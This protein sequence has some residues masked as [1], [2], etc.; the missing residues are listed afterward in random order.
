MITIHGKLIGVGNI[1]TY[2]ACGRGIELEVNGETVYLLGLT[3]EQCADI[4][5]YV[6]EKVSIG[7][8]T[9][10]E[11]TP[12]DVAQILCDNSPRC[13]DGDCTQQH[14]GVE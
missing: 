3:I 6:N 7:V 14:R 4:A 10:K 5:P 8:A 11:Y 12:R 9:Q 1:T 13:D 2:D